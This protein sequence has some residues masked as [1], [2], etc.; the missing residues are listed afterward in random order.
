[1][2]LIHVLGR[3]VSFNCKK[4]IVNWNGSS[5]SNFQREV[6]LFFKQ[7]W[8]SDFCV[9]EFPVIGTRLKCDFINFTRRY[10]VESDGNFHNK[11]NLF[12]HKNRMY[13]LKSVKR[14]LIKEKWFELNSLCILRIKQ[15]ELKFLSPEWIK[16]KYNFDI[17]EIY[18]GRTSI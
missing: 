4:Y 2:K 12:F 11:F 10:A 16:N 13:Y 17:L 18:N 9:E 1:M 15:D 6:K 7:F 5:K 8:F 3:E 14:D